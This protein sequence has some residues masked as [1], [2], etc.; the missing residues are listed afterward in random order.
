MT[1]QLSDD[2]FVD[3]VL[4]FFKKNLNDLDQFFANVDRHHENIVKQQKKESDQN[5]LI[6]FEEY[7]KI[8]MLS[9]LLE[10]IDNHKNKFNSLC[11]NDVK[12]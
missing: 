7:G 3:L 9:V 1:L 11:N 8:R 2:K 10:Y 5:E 12:R 6:P 4:V